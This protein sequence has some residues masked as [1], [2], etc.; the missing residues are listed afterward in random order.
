MDNFCYCFDGG[1]NHFTEPQRSNLV[2]L[3]KFLKYME[4]GIAKLN[5]METNKDVNEF[6]E[7]AE[8]QTRRVDSF[9][10]AESMQGVSMASDF[11]GAKYLLE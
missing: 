6:L 9:V 7:P 11:F 1:H 5:K 2:K 8:T 4:Y 3:L 10:S